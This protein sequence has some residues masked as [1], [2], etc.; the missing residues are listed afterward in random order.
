MS[1][2]SIPDLIAQ[3]AR[4]L[5]ASRRLVVLTGAGGS[6]ESGIPTFRDALE[7]LWAQ[8]DPQELATPFAFQRNPKRVWDWYQHRREL[9]ADAPPNPGHYAIAELE[10]RLPQAIVVTQNVDGL[11]RVAGSSDVIELHGNIR[12]NKCFANCQ[13]DPTLVD[14]STLDWDPAEGPPACPH[15]GAWV[16]PDVVWFHEMLP[17]GALERAHQ[18]C[19]SADVALV[20]GTSGVVQPAASLPFIAK[21]GGATVIEVNPE[22]TPITGIADIRLAGPSGEMLPQVLAAWPESPDA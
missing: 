16:R 15:C 6:K 4:T 9:M 21:R 22:R 18:L 10:K 14:I 19:H 3:A 12:R 5:S 7:G 13:G 11:H 20:V 8:Y 1:T 2:P 17:T